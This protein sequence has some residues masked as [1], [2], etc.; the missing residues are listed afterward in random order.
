VCFG[1]AEGGTLEV[2]LQG[3]N[4]QLPNFFKYVIIL[5]DFYLVLLV[6]AVS[7]VML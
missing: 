6:V 3:G 4:A 2:L 7:L 1:A 5:F